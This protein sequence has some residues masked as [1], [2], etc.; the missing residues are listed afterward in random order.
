MSEGRKDFFSEEKKQ[1]T[2]GRLSRFHPAAFAK[3]ARVF[4]LFFLKK[5][6]FLAFL[7]DEWC[8]AAAVA[9]CAL[10]LSGWGAMAGSATI[11]FMFA[12]AFGCCLSVVRHAE[13]LAVRLGE[14]YGTLILTLAITIIEV[15]S[16]SA[17]VVHG[18]HDAA[19][20]RDTIFAVIM[21]LLNGMVG[22][23]L[24]IGGWRHLEQQ[25]NLLG[26]N[27]T[28]GVIIP[29]T[30]FSLILPNYTMTTPGPTLSLAQEVF[31]AVVSLGLYGV[32]LAVQTVRHR[33]YFKPRDTAD[34]SDHE[35]PK[36]RRHHPILH[37][38]L[39][40]CYMVP[41]VY[42]AE[43]F[44]GP[45][46]AVLARFH[47]PAALGGVV[48]ALLV[49]TPEA[50]SAIRAAAANRL[51]RSMNILLGS[52][53]STTGLTIPVMIGVTRVQG[54]TL[55]LGLQNANAVLLVLTL[56]VSMVTFA[57]GRTNI[58]QGAIHLVLFGAYIMLMIEG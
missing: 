5:N 11:I 34:A 56:A 53:L 28:L 58:L 27:T 29:L 42:L 16:I 19:L 36:G 40:V 25:F 10:L 33:G 50:L 24:L 26:A 14:P 20:V 7:T 38:A 8:F 3:I 43:R 35:A 55:V 6:A 39:M 52:V 4:W 41:L 49:A 46:D 21:I 32:F 44:A 57:S 23:S 51:Q 54:G 9:I 45:V 48:V 1:K 13:H 2:F 31:L 12:A 47:A 30:V 37:A 15:V 18:A 22:L 17:L